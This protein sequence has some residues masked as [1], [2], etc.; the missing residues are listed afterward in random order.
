MSHSRL[1]KKNSYHGASLSSS[2]LSVTATSTAERH[3]QLTPDSRFSRNEPRLLMSV[4]AAQALL[5]IQLFAPRDDS[6]FLLKV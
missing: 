2:Y 1:L 6:K 5:N 3:S 4:L